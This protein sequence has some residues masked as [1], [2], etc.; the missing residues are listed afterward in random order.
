MYKIAI[1]D[2]DIEYSQFLEKLITENEKYSENMQ[3]FRFLSGEELLQNKK[4]SYQLVFLDME[5]KNLDGYETARRLREVNKDFVLAFCTGI[6]NPTAEY[7]KVQPYRYL[8]KQYDDYK[9]SMEISELL[10]EMMRREIVNYFGVVSDGMAAKININDIIYIS[11]LKRGCQIK[12]TQELQEKGIMGELRSKEKLG[13]V[14]EELK[15]FGFEFAQS[16]CLVN[17]KNILYTEHN[18]LVLNNQE[19]LN[20]TRACKDIFYQRWT[21][22][23]GKKYRRG[24]K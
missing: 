20:I 17:F 7:F 21:D 11:K 3:F 13:T 24:T 6:R 8:M 15:E 14:Y 12:I 2:D 4:Q 16:S 19:R 9:M 5:M 1:C 10:E 23:I 22:Y 18:E